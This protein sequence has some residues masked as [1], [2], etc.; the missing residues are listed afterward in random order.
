MPTY[1]P[2]TEQVGNKIELSI[3]PVNAAGAEG[4]IVTKIMDTAVVADKVFMSVVMDKKAK[5]GEKITMKVKVSS[6]ED[7]K[8]PISGISIVSKVSSATN[9]KGGTETPS[10]QIDGKVSDTKESDVNGEVTFEIS[11]DKGKGLE[12]TILIT[13]NKGDAITRK[14][15]FTV[16]TSPDSQYAKYWGHMEDISKGVKRP[17]LKDEDSGAPQENTE[18]GEVWAV[19]K[20]VSG[21]NCSLPTKEALLAIYGSNGGVTKK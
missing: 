11:D 13:P 15:T 4:A 1:V 9:R 14:A 7:G 8:S 6:D 17:K 5:V 20:N 10:A 16:I 3:L 19:H 21:K 2:T 12:T 18:N